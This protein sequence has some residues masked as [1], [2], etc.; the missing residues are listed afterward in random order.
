MATGTVEPRTLPPPPPA[1]VESVE[2]ERLIRRQLA[3]TGWHVRLVDL[4]SSLVVW[5]IGLLLLFLFAAAADHL[6]GLGTVGRCIG[7]AAIVAFSV[8]YLT[9]HV[10]PL[11]VRAINPAYAAR[12]IEEATPTLKNSLINFLLLRQDRHGLKEIV[13][14]AVERQAAADIADVP[15]EATV[16]RTRL[17]YAGYALCAVMTFFAAYKILSPKDP[18]QTIARVMAPWAEIAR[19]SRVQI[20]EVD[21]GSTEVYYGQAVKIA[22]T[23]RGVRDGDKINLL[24]STADG[25]TIDQPV[26]MKLS[27]GNRYEC[28]LPPEQASPSAANG[29]LQNVTYR[30]VAGDA[31]T[32]PYRL[33]VVAAPTIIVDRLEFQF[34]AYSRKA[35]ESVRQQGDIKALEG[36]KV[37]IHAIANQPIKSAFIELDPETKGGAG[38]TVPLIADGQ[39]ARGTITL[40]LRPDRQTA[41]RTTYQV[42]FLNERGQR[43]Q[44]PILHRIQVLRDLAP[45][46]QILSPESLRISVAEDGEQTIEVRAIDPDFGL[47]KL[48]LEGTVAGKEPLTIDLLEDAA[49]Q[50]PQV[51][52][53]YAFR[54]RDHQLQAGDELKF[55]AVAEDNRAHSLTGQPEPNVTRT[56]EYTLL[57]TDARKPDQGKTGQNQQP[58]GAGQKGKKPDEKTQPANDLKSKQGPQKNSQ[59]SGDK[60]DQA[61]DQQSQKGQEKNGSEKNGD[62]QDGQQSKTEQRQPNNSDQQNKQQ[63]SDQ[64]SE[65]KPEPNGEQQ[66]GQQKSGEQQAGKQQGDQQK[67][68]EQQKG[69]QQKGQQQKGQQQ[70]GQQQSDQQK[71]QQG[72]QQQDGQQQG[73]KGKQGGQAGKGSQQGN[74]E[75]GEPQPGESAG[76]SGQ[77]GQ[78]RGNS[79]KAGNQPPGERPN[80]S[81]G[82]P[83]GEPAGSEPNGG[84]AQHD[85][86]AIERI[87]KEL[88]KRGEDSQPAGQNP[89]NN[90]QTSDGNNQP[91]GNQSDSQPAGQSQAKG[92]SGAKG[93]NTP[94][95]GTPEGNDQRLDPSGKGSQ[96]QG[97]GEKTGD[98][99]NDQKHGQNPSEQQSNGSKGGESHGASKTDKGEQSSDSKGQQRDPGAGKTGDEGAG[100]ASTDKSGSGDGVFQNRDRKKEQQP[101]TNQPGQ[102]E[103]SPANSTHK[104]N[105]SKGGSSGDNSGGGKQGAGQAGAQEGNDSAGSKSAGDQGAGKAQETGSGET[106]SKAGQQRPAAGKTGQSGTE[107][108]AGSASRA[109]ERDPMSGTGVQPV[110]NSGQAGNS[111]S[112]SNSGQPGKPSGEKPIGGGNDTGEPAP[113]R[114]PSA[115]DQAAD[116]ANLEY[117]RKAT[118]MVLRRLK[119]EQHNPDPELLDKLGW[120]REDLAEFLR[121]WENL[122]KSATETPS[123]K[124]EL[125]EALKSLGLRDPANRRRAG[126]KT[127]DNQRDL[128]DSG[129]R[130]VAPPKYR[131]MFDA[132]RKGAARSA[133]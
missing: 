59:P 43:S 16:D 75:T 125:D 11:L 34:P 95:T 47:A 83:S 57:V 96:S 126:G 27:A 90:G 69:E 60:G 19:P 102:N 115:E 77:K 124:R 38:E 118:E 46:V 101:D 18:F 23:V 29:L 79:G 17:I 5:V 120:T 30:I 88:Q 87:W 13:Y 35:D 81:S 131:E 68:G 42:R 15:V 50:P 117:A 44:Q 24:Y 114:P 40:Q 37:T 33:N 98:R 41:W 12:T 51:T 72:D 66:N 99:M 67:S 100:Q 130:S 86:Q 108:G 70:S 53:P 133:P 21:P 112:P 106:G 55:S 39:N 89:S 97:K 65:G 74:E 73:G 94:N 54:P 113:P 14:Q 49:K 93:Q 127:S 104:Q 91:S 103:P 111:P 31:E 123:G 48:Y 71:N 84:K 61:G 119:D 76:P 3:R 129:N 78:S 64:Q 52:I 45:E 116:A 132:F 122:E 26:A 32:F 63:P 4:G 85:G 92:S 58:G 105:D 62:K 6:V 8:W 121:R 110:S 2:R 10:G 107:K 82:E 109:G 128:R 36:T 9:M 1:P 7:L 56:K 20:S 25:Q 28:S 22:A 80:D